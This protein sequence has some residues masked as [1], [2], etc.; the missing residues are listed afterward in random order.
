MTVAALPLDAFCDFQQHDGAWRC[1]RCGTK[2]S[3]PTARVCGTAT[4]RRK[5]AH[6]LECPHRQEVINTIGARSAGTG[7]ESTYVE[8]Y[9]CAKFNEPVLKQAGHTQSC[10]ERITLAAPGY[11]GRTCRECKVPMVEQKPKPSR[12]PRTLPYS[13]D[14]LLGL[15]DRCLTNVDTGIVTGGSAVHWPCLGALAI[16]AHQHGYGFAVADHGLTDWQRAELKRCGAIFVEHEKPHVNTTLDR[17][18]IVSHA[19]A[20]WKPFVCRESPFRLSSW[21]DSDAVVV[22][23]LNDLFLLAETRFCISDQRLWRTS[24]KLYHELIGATHGKE[25]YEQVKRTVS[26]IN[27]GVFAWMRGDTL[28]DEWCEV[29]AR[30]LPDAELR[31]FCRVRD[32]SIMAI[33]LADRMLAGR[34][35]YALVDPRYNVPADNLGATQSSSRRPIDLRPQRLLAEAIQRHPGAAVVHW[36]GKPKAWEI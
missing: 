7:C 19:N 36:L 31:K 30:I 32:Q 23:S 2:V 10:L 26:D 3:Y 14:N 33:V 20:Y 8:I 35:G 15:P 13:P 22:A 24:M 16:S 9:R 27:T 21:I 29:T 5:L 12:K 6:Y 4:V 25:A 17:S 28:I 11:T 18:A 34:G 1:L